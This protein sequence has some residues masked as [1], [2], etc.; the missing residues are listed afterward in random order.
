DLSARLERL[1][2][3]HPSSPYRDYGIRKP[4]PPDLSKYELPLPDDLDLP[5]VEPPH[6]SP[7]GS[8][9][10]KG[11]HLTPEQSLAA[12]RILTERDA[13]EGRD[14]EGNYGEHGLTPAM[15][16]VE[17]QLDHGHLVEDTEKFALKD[18]DSFK[19]KVADLIIRNPDKPYDELAHEI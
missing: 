4:P 9:D 11:R 15:R 16:R 18:P 7:D 8:W 19:E 12:N 10:Y 13:N 5:P 17:A 14:A 6:C 3:G 1:P 2:V